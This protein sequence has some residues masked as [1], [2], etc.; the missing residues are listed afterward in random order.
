MQYHIQK[1]FFPILQGLLLG[2]V[3]VMLWSGTVHAQYAVLKVEKGTALIKRDGRELLLESPREVFIRDGDILQVGG[4]GMVRMQTL[5]EREVEI[6]LSANSVF[7]VRDFSQNNLEG[8]LRMLFGR[9]R[10][11]S[12]ANNQAAKRFA[13][14]IPS[15][16]VGVKGTEYTADVDETGNSLLL[17][18]ESQVEL[19]NLL[20]Q[21]VIVDTG[22]IGGSIEGHLARPLDAPQALV[23]QLSGE[24][25][26]AAGQGEAGGKSLLDMVKFENAD[27][28]DFEDPEN[29]YAVA[30]EGGDSLS[31][32]QAT[33]AGV[34]GATRVTRATEGTGSSQRLAVP[35]FASGAPLA[36]IEV[37]AELGGVENPLG[38][39]LSADLIDL[40][41]VMP[42]S[43]RSPLPPGGELATGFFGR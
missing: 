38:S 40:D 18:T 33:E 3:V 1:S 36:E 8:K 42:P 28:S 24:Q 21:S 29:F 6:L 41:T 25:A 14:K 37:N 2:A 22:R 32:A 26:L 11:R 34:A 7:M 39:H 20:K 43:L 27:A 16:I 17:V 13:V 4:Q 10:L 19:Q 23:Q 12:I 31:L 35:P 5:P 15:A 30:S 9:F